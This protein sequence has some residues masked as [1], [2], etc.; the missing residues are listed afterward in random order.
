VMD[1]HDVISLQDSAQTRTDL[2]E[3]L[4]N[5]TQDDNGVLIR[6]LDKSC[7]GRRVRKRSSSQPNSMAPRRYDY[8]TA[9]YSDSHEWL[10]LVHYCTGVSAWVIGYH[11]D[12][13]DCTRYEDTQEDEHE[14]DGLGFLDKA[15]ICQ[16]GFLH[17]R[18]M[19]EEPHDFTKRC[20]SGCG[21][22]NFSALTIPQSLPYWHPGNCG[23]L[24]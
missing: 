6:V 17:D 10:P 4:I 20:P 9:R 8:N 19:H 1:L 11:H 14:N 15:R 3:G 5:F 16:T 21:K 13:R 24:E 12:P 23:P 18:G 22:V 7:R 2:Y